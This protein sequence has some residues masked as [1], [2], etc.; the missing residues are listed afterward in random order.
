MYVVP[1]HLYIYAGV[2]G[3]S[4]HTFPPVT[5]ISA[6]PLLSVSPTDAYPCS[7]CW[8]RVV[9][10]LLHAPA[11]YFHTLNVKG[12][13]VLYGPDL[14]V[15]TRL[16][17]PSPSTSPIDRLV[18][19]YHG[20]HIPVA[21]YTPGLVYTTSTI[22]GHPIV[23]AYIF[24]FPSHCIS[25]IHRSIRLE[26][27]HIDI[28]SSGMIVSTNAHPT[29]SNIESF[30]FVFHSFA[31]TTISLYPSLFRSS[32]CRSVLFIPVFGILY[33]C[34][35][36]I[37]PSAFTGAHVHICISWLLPDTTTISALP[38]WSTSPTSAA[39]LDAEL[40]APVKG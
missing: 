19:P 21:V 34:L 6:T 37:F 38:S 10:V 32:S 29:N 17:D 28:F 25:Y 33:F 14:L 2:V 22:S 11:L 26:L 31:H 16:R 15:V 12:V 36:H 35:Y 30:V 23:Y 24:F 18:H 8:G 27:S 1:F 4:H 39:T 9:L 7:S 20:F 40:C 5:T 3:H 13:F